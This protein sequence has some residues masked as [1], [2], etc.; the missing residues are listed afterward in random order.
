MNLGSFASFAF[1]ASFLA[2]LTNQSLASYRYDIRPLSDAA[3]TDFDYRQKIWTGVHV[4]NDGKLLVS[5]VR[6]DGLTDHCDELLTFEHFKYDRLWREYQGWPVELQLSLVLKSEYNF[7]I[8]A[9]PDFDVLQFTIEDVLDV[10]V[11]EKLRREI[12]SVIYQVTNDHPSKTHILLEKTTALMRIMNPYWA[13]HPITLDQMTSITASLE[14]VETVKALELL[15]PIAYKIDLFRLVLLYHFGGVYT[16]T[17][18]VPIV[19]FDHFLPEVGGMAPLDLDG[20]GLYNAFLAFPSHSIMLKRAIEAIIQNVEEQFYG[21]HCLDP[22]GPHLLFNVYQNLSSQ[23]QFNCAITIE[24]DQ[25]AR[26]IRDRLTNEPLIVAH[27][28]EYRRRF[29]GRN[30]CHYGRLFRS[31]GVYHEFKCDKN[32]SLLQKSYMEIRKALRFLF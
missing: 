16:D 22:S 11:V 2:S 24:L 15:Q 25:D 18:F 12:P 10:D 31:K 28:S 21:T 29:T 8:P 3:P 1:N 5:L 14:G 17:R 19:P 13:Y 26:F 23:E 7:T 6:L 30:N 4:Q 32:P 27:N 20:L 9:N